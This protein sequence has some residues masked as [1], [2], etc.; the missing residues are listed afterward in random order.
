MKNKTKRKIIELIVKFC[1]IVT[2]IALSFWIV[3]CFKYGETSDYSAILA[4]IWVSM[5][6]LSLFLA[7]K[8][9]YAIQRP[10]TKAHEFP[11]SISNFNDFIK[12]LDNN[13]SEIGY[14]KFSY[15]NNYKELVCVYYK[16]T[17]DIL[18]YYG[19][20]HFDEIKDTKIKTFEYAEKL[21]EE[22]FRIYYQGQDI[23][24]FWQ[25]TCIIWVD[26][27]NKNFKDIININLTQGKYDGLLIVGVSPSNRTIYVADQKEGNFKFMYRKLLKN[28]LKVMH[29]KMKDKI[30]K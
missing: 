20:Y 25:E 23:R 2:L 4:C 5:A 29:L 6:F 15:L 16:K 12:Y 7:C 10:K 21:M 30:K 9:P 19:V 13:M 11:L 18:E 14:E 28:F 27:E 26:K 8:F 1:L 3:I 22:F 24:E 17:R